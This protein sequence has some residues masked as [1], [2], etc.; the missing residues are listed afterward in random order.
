[1]YPPQILARG[2]AST[3]FSALAGYE[4]SKLHVSVESLKEGVTHGGIS[5]LDEVPDG[6]KSNKREKAFLVHCFKDVDKVLVNEHAFCVCHALH[7]MVT[8]TIGESEFVG[9]L[10]AVQHVASIAQ[11][12]NQIL[13]ACRHV[14]SSELMIVPGSPPEEYDLQSQFILDNF[15]FR[16]EESTRSEADVDGIAASRRGIAARSQSDGFRRYINGNKALCRH[17]HCCNDCCLDA[18]DTSSRE[19]CIDNFMGAL[20]GIG[21]LSGSNWINAPGKARWLSSSTTLAIIIAGLLIHGLLAKVWDVAFP[22]WTIEKPLNGSEE[23]D[24]HRQVRSKCYRAKLYLCGENTLWRGCCISVATQP[25]DHLMQRLQAL[26]EAGGVLLDLQSCAD[27][28]HRCLQSLFAN[29]TTMV[30]KAMVGLMIFF[31]IKGS[32]FTTCLRQ[33]IF[34]LSFALASLIWF[35]LESLFSAAP[36]ALLGLVSA[37]STDETR[38]TLAE[39]FFNTAECCLDRGVSLKIRRLVGSPEDLIT[40]TPILLVLRMWARR[41]RIGNMGLERLL[42]LIRR[43]APKGCSVERLVVGGFLAQ[44][45]RQHLS[46]GGTDVRKMTRR[47]CNEAG[48]PLRGRSSKLKGRENLMGT[49]NRCRGVRRIQKRQGRKGQWM[50]RQLQSLKLRDGA[51]SRAKW[52][53]SG[54][55]LSDRWDSGLHGDFVESQDPTDRWDSR[56]HGELARYRELTESYGSRIGNDLWGTSS[57]NTPFTDE[58]FEGVLKRE[59]PSSCGKTPGLTGRLAPLRQPFINDVYC[60]DKGCIPAAQRMTYECLCHHCHPGLCSS[61]LH[62]AAVSFH[63]GL[64]RVV[65]AWPAGTLFGVRSDYYDV[66]DPSEESAG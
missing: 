22:N 63:R 44:I 32:D 31:A 36:Y 21:L 40:N 42:S 23:S 29:A 61:S 60:A 18:T 9:H 53:Q 16:K 14:L 46:A 12:R 50:N 52:Q 49:K 28:I 59:V 58:Q 2:N 6:C 65:S 54:S 66:P 39:R 64:H 4:G 11:R 33:Y 3:V 37:T 48:V 30:P 17:G 19:R 8:K 51:R 24:W 35:N 25:V 62:E 41:G 47:Q 27:P 13:V 26:D 43:N 10:H 5:F 7:N 57:K 55:R 15:I 45:M 56:L 38:R 34:R 1:M 20:T